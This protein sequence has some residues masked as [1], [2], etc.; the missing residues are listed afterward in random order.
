MN[1]NDGYLSFGLDLRELR[2]AHDDTLLAVVFFERDTD[3]LLFQIAAPN[4]EHTTWN[5]AQVC[6]GGEP[7]LEFMPLGTAKT[8][9]GAYSL[10]RKAFVA[11]ALTRALHESRRN[12]P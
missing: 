5:A 11:W 3:N 2:D 7:P 10:V 12:R 8:R 4:H 1:I 9:R 6:R